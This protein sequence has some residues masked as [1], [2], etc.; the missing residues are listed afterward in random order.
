MPR[1]K[2]GE[3]R[4]IPP[5]A[6]VLGA[7][8]FGRRHRGGRRHPRNIGALLQPAGELDA[9]FDQRE[10]RVVLAVADVP[11]GT[12]LRS[13]TPDHS[14]FRTSEVRLVREPCDLMFRILGSPYPQK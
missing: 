9:D 7:A 10:D 6:T 8:L 14:L 13:A 1:T 3:R 2:K 11:A 4:T 5:V 12:I